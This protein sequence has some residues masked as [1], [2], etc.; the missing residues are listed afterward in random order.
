MCL[1]LAGQRVSL[2]TQERLPFAPVHR[3]PC[4]IALKLRRRRHIPGLAGSRLRGRIASGTL[5]GD[6]GLQLRQLLRKRKFFTLNFIT[7]TKFIFPM[8]VPQR[9]MQ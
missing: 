1:D 8:E 6:E 7:E 3:T 5:A 4:V 2:T 9:E